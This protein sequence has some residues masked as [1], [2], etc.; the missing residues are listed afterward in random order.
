MTEVGSIYLILFSYLSSRP[1]NFFLKIAIFKLCMYIVCV[2]VEITYIITY[3]GLGKSRFAVVCM[4]NN[5][6]TQI[7]I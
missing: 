5:T 6:I 7:I 2:S 4:E 3:T 1:H